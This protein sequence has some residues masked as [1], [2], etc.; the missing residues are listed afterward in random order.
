MKNKQ[1]D[2]IGLFREGK[3]MILVHNPLYAKYVCPHTEEIKLIK[4]DNGLE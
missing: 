4:I 2:Y 3:E 1:W